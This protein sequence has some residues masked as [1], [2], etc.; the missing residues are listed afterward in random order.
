MDD[1]KSHKV[2]DLIKEDLFNVDGF[3]DI[4]RPTSFYQTAGDYSINGDNDKIA[5]QKTAS[6]SSLEKLDRKNAH[7][8]NGDTIKHV[9]MK[10]NSRFEN[11]G[12]TVMIFMGILLWLSFLNSIEK[13][14]DSNAGLSGTVLI[15]VG[16]AYKS[17]KNRIL[18]GT[19]HPN[20]R[21][22]FEVFL[23]LISASSI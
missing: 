23:L 13:G 6:I 18:Y 16:I 20:L 3:E 7:L 14:Q 22:L 8:N 17:A 9:P 1:T 2:V 10:K 11:L 5:R 19:N 12:S 21:L 15:L 4:L